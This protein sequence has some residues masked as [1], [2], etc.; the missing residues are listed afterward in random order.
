M[1]GSVSAGP[2]GTELTHGS[3]LMLLD[4]EALLTAIPNLK[5]VSSSAAAEPSLTRVPCAVFPLRPAT[6]SLERIT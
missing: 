1:E 6:P 3:D 4:E 2:T 5:S